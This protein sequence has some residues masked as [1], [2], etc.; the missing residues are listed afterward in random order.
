[1]TEQRRDEPVIDVPQFPEGYL[2]PGQELTQLPWSWAVERLEKAQNYWFATV[3]PN[4]RPH[5]MPAWAVWLDGALYFEGSP[6]TRRARN[7]AENPWISVHLESGSEVV[8]LEGR[9][10]A[11]PKP[12]RALGERLAKAFGDK[13]GEGEFEYRPEPTQWDEGGLWRLRP[14]TAIGWSTFNK[15]PTRWRW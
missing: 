15:D 5:T 10:A 8:V 14:R 11:H 2:L 13:Y 9:A 7:I 1:M 6:E 3:R 12:D 4:G